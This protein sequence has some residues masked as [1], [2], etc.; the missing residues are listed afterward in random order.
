MVPGTSDRFSL[1]DSILREALDLPAE[2]RRR[3]VRERCGSDGEL[4]NSL[5]R[6][7]A[8]F[9]QLGDFLEKPAIASL[10]SS[11]VLAPGVTLGRGR[12][13]IASFIGRGGMGEVYRAEDTELA[14]PVALKTVRSI[15]CADEKARE[16]FRSEIR[17]SRQISSPNVCRIFDLVT[18]Q[19]DGKDLLFFTME[20]LE[21][22]TLAA[23]LARGP[24]DSAEIV[25]LAAALADGLAAAHK[26][27]IVHCDLKP[28]NIMLT[29]GPEG[30]GRIVIMDFGLATRMAGSESGAPA[31]EMVGS[32]DYMA[33][34]QF[35]GTAPTP[36]TDV[37]ALG[38]I[39]YEMTAGRRPFPKESLLRTALRRVSRDAPD[40]RTASPG[41]PAHVAAAVKRALALEPTER[42]QSAPQFI[43]DLRAGS[44]IPRR[45]A[46][47]GICGIAV[48]ASAVFLRLRKQSRAPA[49]PVLMIMPCNYAENDGRSRSMAQIMDTLVGVQLSQSA[50]VRLLRPEQIEAAWHLLGSAGTPRLQAMEPRTARQIVLRGSGERQT[51]FVLFGNIARA[52]DHYSVMLSLERVG[53]NPDSAL[54]GNSWHRDI[55]SGGCA[56]GRTGHRSSVARARRMLVGTI[57]S[58]QSC[59][60]PAQ[61]AVL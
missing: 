54:E 26:Q 60:G 34:E 17:L 39:V 13:R 6:L 19:I 48:A 52:G 41:T 33:P 10:P 28:A 50:Y 16:R 20:Y 11:E 24:M 23:R 55:D 12:F 59:L 30:A 27:G 47:A 8:K 56:S 5:I 31:E 15:W 32:P 9:D 57:K 36:A 18:E 38:V 3:L 61:I 29:A 7:I 21:G 37:Y 44:R 42:Y 35:F 58:G 43:A 49:E 40:L 1:A 53:A 14:V 46:V 2:D 51:P 4:E 22:E 45:L 25:P